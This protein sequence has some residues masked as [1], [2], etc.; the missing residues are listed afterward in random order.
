MAYRPLEGTHKVT[1]RGYGASKE[2]SRHQARC[3]YFK[4]NSKCIL[5]G[6]CGGSSHCNEYREYC[7]PMPKPK[8]EEEKPPVK[9]TEGNTYFVADEGS[10]IKGQKVVLEEIKIDEYMKTKYLV[11]LGNNTYIVKKLAPI[12]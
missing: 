1:Y 3:K 5:F 12:E 11:R 2:P 6:R 7:R 4:G 8:V 10:G 9:I